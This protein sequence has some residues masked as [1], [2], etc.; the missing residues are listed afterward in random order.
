MLLAESNGLFRRFV[1]G[2]IEESEN[3]AETTDST[4]AY[5]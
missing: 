1:A 4:R 5:L 3:V 2:W